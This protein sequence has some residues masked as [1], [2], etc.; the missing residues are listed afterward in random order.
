MKQAIRPMQA[1]FH[2]LPLARDVE[3]G[4]IGLSLPDVVVVVVVVI[5]AAAMTAVAPVAD[6]V[7]VVGYVGRVASLLLDLGLLIYHC[8][9]GP[10]E[11]TV[12]GP[13][14]AW[15]ILSIFLLPYQ[16]FWSF[17]KLSCEMWSW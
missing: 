7:V 6:Q 13:E 14:M 9:R 5:V 8:D 3:W 11:K 1:H 16:L 17:L 12:L 4:L 2:L 15:H 10:F